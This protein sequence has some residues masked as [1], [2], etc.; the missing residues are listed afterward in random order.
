MTLLSEVLC[1]CIPFT[2]I[3]I[4]TELSSNPSVCL[5]MGGNVATMHSNGI[6]VRPELGL[7]KLG[8]VLPRASKGV[9]G[10]GCWGGPAGLRAP[11]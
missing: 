5:V 2:F 6:P 11:V 1:V 8:V 4:P 3:P 7:R 10:M 9:K